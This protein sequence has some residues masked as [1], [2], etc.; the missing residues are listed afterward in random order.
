MK[1]KMRSLQLTQPI[2]SLAT[3]DSYILIGYS[4]VLLADICNAE[5]IIHPV[6]ESIDDKVYNMCLKTK[7]MCMDSLDSK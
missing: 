3:S 7:K 4:G 2:F 5:W 6:I 1:K